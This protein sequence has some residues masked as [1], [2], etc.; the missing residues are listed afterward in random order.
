VK[1]LDR[2]FENLRSNNRKA[3]IP[4]FT[5]GYPDVP[6]FLALV[7]EASKSGADLI[8]IGIPFSDPIA[9]GPTIQYSSARA[10]K[11]GITLSQTL[12][13]IKKLTEM[14]PT[15]LLVMS[16][17]NPILKM[18]V[19]QFMKAANEA[20]VAGLIVPD[21]PVEEVGLLKSEARTV[22]IP[23]IL[24]LAPTSSDKRIEQVDAHAE[25]FIYLVSIAGVTGARDRLAGEALRLAARVRSKT[26]LP[27]CVG[28]GI[29]NP[30]QAFCLSREADGVIIGSA[31]VDIIRKAGEGTAAISQVGS[32]L[33]AVRRGIDT[34]NDNG[35][36]GS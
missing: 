34:G 5:A 17:L 26:T 36:G 25:G 6:T 22:G 30:E 32:F 21:L 10:L 27:V 2:V 8:E 18:G 29:S 35:N 20:G 15:P 28:F 9:D 33:A 7:M 1:T 24:F 12:E 23:L 13:L 11:T 3:L 31:I 16:Y 19:D 4:F 14:I